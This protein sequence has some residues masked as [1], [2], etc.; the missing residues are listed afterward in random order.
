MEM[1]NLVGCL[2]DEW[3]DGRKERTMMG[4]P[5]WHL[6]EHLDRLTRNQDVDQ[7]SEFACIK[8]DSSFFIFCQVDINAFLFGHFSVSC[9]HQGHH[10]S[11][12]PSDP[13][14]GSITGAF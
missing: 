10:C 3:I 8:R 7:V 13:P 12:P 4:L 6:E 11:L 5:D 2:R 9:F 1:D 14:R